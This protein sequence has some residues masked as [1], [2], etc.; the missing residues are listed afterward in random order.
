[1]INHGV[2][3]ELMDE[4]MKVTKEFHEMPAIEKARECSKDPKNRCKLYTSSENYSTEKLH[5]WRDA[6]VHPCHPLE[7]YI[8][9]WPE[10]PT[11]Y[12]YKIKSSFFVFS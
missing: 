3:E 4:T 2:S 10:N 1:M 6:L 5:Y 11:R 7:E 8:Q 12:R 9:F